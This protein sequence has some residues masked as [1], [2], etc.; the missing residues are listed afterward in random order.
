MI[1]KDFNSVVVARMSSLYLRARWFWGAGL[2]LVA[3]VVGLVTGESGRLWVVAAA[4][5][6]ILLHALGLALWRLEVVVS[7]LFVDLLVA[8]GAVTVVIVDQPET[9]APL[10][11]MVG[12]SVLITLFVSGLTKWAALTINSALTFVTM[13][14]AH[15]WAFREVIGPF[16]G[17]LFVVGIVIAVVASFQRRVAVLEELRALTLGIA[18][19]ELKNRLTGVIGVTQL[20]NEGGVAPESEEGR[21]LIELVHREA[22]EAG[23]V[24]EDLLTVSRTERGALETNPESTD[25]AEIVRNVVATIDHHGDSIPVTGADRPV[26]A[27]AD[28][29]RTPQVLRNLLTNA[30]RYGGGD[31]RVVLSTGEGMVSILVSDNGDGVHPDEVPKLFTPYHQAKEREPVHGSTGLGLWISRSLMRS[32]G[33]DL[34]YR[35]LEDRTVFEALFPS[36]VP[37]DES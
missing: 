27:M 9:G 29:L 33:G 8:H 30:D 7:T 34:I 11:T 4:G 24:I 17:G 13:M 19:H 21:E 23:A 26:W 28:R 16:I 18:S 37:H 6:V 32:M 31:V 22:V 5:A 10:L 2:V 12:F 35:R 25:I 20:L 36:S 15:D 3:V 14:L 1:E